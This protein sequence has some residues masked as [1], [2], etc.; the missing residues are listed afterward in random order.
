MILSCSHPIFLYCSAEQMAS[1]IT[2]SLAM[3]NMTF[4]LTDPF[5]ATPWAASNRTTRSVLPKPHRRAK[6]KAG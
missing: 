5:T 1:P 6:T 4:S 2:R 3:L